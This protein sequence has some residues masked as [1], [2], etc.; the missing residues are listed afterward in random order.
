MSRSGRRKWRRIAKFFLLTVIRGA[1][2]LHEPEKAGWPVFQTD[3]HRHSS[4]FRDAPCPVVP[5]HCRGPGASVIQ[6][7]TG[8]SRYMRPCL[9]VRRIDLFSRS[10]QP[11]AHGERI[12]GALTFAEFTFC[13]TQRGAESTVTDLASAVSN[14]LMGEGASLFTP[15][16]LSTLG[17]ARAC[18]R[19]RPRTDRGRCQSCRLQLPQR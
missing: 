12:T 13:D 3:T 2:L 17:N 14:N 1:A 10:H 16:R 11:M 9:Q 8:R 6:C 15:L 19:H 4:L 5:A 18:L 7:G